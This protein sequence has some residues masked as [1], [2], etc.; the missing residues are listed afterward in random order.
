MPIF[1]N[2]PIG[3]AARAHDITAGHRD[4]SAYRFDPRTPTNPPPSAP[5]PAQ[6]PPPP[7][8]GGT[9]IGAAASGDYPL[10]GLLSCAA[11]QLPL[12]PIE[13]LGGRAY[14]A[15][16]GCRLTVLSAD[17]LERLVFDALAARDP[18]ARDCGEA[19]ARRAALS[20]AVP[21]DRP[22]GVP[23]RDRPRDAADPGV[24]AEVR[25]CW[26]ALFRRHLAEVRVGGTPEDL[27]LV[28]IV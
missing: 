9:V 21:G 20:E 23:R 10:V 25:R 5:G 11:C 4:N 16:C 26:A 8:T 24:P 18:A 2:T 13:M 14:G 27:F 22:S 1:H 7:P 19:A 6:P 15:P 28:W 3:P 17:V 12:R